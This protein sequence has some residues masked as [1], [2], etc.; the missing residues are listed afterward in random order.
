[1][2]RLGNIGRSPHL[3]VL[4]HKGERLDGGHRHRHLHCNRSDS[5]S[6]IR[7]KEGRVKRQQ[8]V[9]SRSGEGSRTVA[10]KSRLVLLHHWLVAVG[11]RRTPRQS[12]HVFPRVGTLRTRMRHFLRHRHQHIPGT[13]WFCFLTERRPGGSKA[14][15]RTAAEVWV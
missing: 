12:L 14:P 3:A 9:P 13:A 10:V 6:I 8:R 7:L 4:D 15:T 5:A 11:W 1:M 2:S